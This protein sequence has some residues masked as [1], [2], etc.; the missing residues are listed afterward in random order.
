M[1]DDEP[2]GEYLPPL[3]E[4]QHLGFVLGTAFRCLS[5][6]ATNSVKANE[7][8]KLRSEANKFYRI[9]TT[10]KE[11]PLAL[12]TNSR[13]RTALKTAMATMWQ[14]T[15]TD[16]ERMM[17][18]KGV[19]RRLGFEAIAKRVLPPRS[20]HQERPFQRE[21]DEGRKL[22]NNERAWA[23]IWLSVNASADY[24]D[25]DHKFEALQSMAKQCW[26]D[27]VYFLNP[28][29]VDLFITPGGLKNL[30]KEAVHD[31]DAACSSK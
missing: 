13:Q 10:R 24:T 1:T 7:A 19:E 11:K 15:N 18:L 28:L 16:T 29:G 2:I 5:K 20:E 27:G 14:N 25:F 9:R 21:G 22:K 3:T 12:V 4:L 17:A 8:K 23:A 30:A 31:L 6:E 26:S